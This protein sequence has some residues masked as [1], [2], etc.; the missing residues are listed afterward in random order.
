MNTPAGIGM[1]VRNFGR[2]P[3]SGGSPR[4]TAR[5]TVSA[6]LGDGPRRAQDRFDRPMVVFSVHCVPLTEAGARTAP[7]RSRGSGNR[8][9]RTNCSP[10]LDGQGSQ[11]R[12]PQSSCARSGAVNPRAPLRAIDSAFWPMAM[13]DEDGDDARRMA[14]KPR[15]SGSALRLRGAG[16]GNPIF[17]PWTLPAGL[18]RTFRSALW[19][20]QWPRPGHCAQVYASPHGTETAAAPRILGHLDAPASPESAAAG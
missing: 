16:F 7:R 11:K 14:D 9:Q 4:P 18:F 20:T 6:P 17:P 8:G 1:G 3:A 5:R 19:L 13:M 12:L 10:G 2:H 15:G